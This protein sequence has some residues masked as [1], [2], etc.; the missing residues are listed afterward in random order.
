MRVFAPAIVVRR[1]LLSGKP[2][3]SKV[4]AVNHRRQAIDGAGKAMDGA[5]RDRRIAIFMVSSAVREITNSGTT[6]L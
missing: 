1:A 3:G 2:A 4:P 5:R 6:G